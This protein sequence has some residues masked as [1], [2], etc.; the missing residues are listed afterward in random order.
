[1][2]THMSAFRITV[3]AAIAVGCSALGACGQS[4]PLYLPGNP[5]DVRQVPAPPPP[6]ADSSDDGEDD[7][8]P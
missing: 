7:A 8:A 6:A 4:G 2:A 5:S 3:I 1:M